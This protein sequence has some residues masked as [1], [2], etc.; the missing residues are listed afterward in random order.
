MS[1]ARDLSRDEYEAM[2]AAFVG[3]WAARNRAVFVLGVRTGYRVSEILSLNV[4][5]VIDEDNR[6]LD[7][8]EVRRANMKGKK[9]SRAVAV[10]PELVE[11]LRKYLAWLD[12]KCLNHSSLPLFPDQHGKALNRKEYWR[13]VKGA[14]RRAGLQTRGISTHTM[15]KSFAT[16]IHG[17]FLSARESGERLDPIFEVQAALGHTKV[18]STIKYLRRDKTRLANAVRSL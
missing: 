8:I 3:R 9:T 16:W 13:V 15:R 4:S 2:K 1:V 14:A 5:D 11:E 17:H 7:E 6:L 12:S 10:H 18:D